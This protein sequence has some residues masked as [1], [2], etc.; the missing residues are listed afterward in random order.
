[1]NYENGAGNKMDHEIVRSEDLISVIIPVYNTKKYLD[2][3]LKSVFDQR[4][5]KLEIIIID[6]GSTDGTGELCDY[7]LDIDK[8]V[9]VFHKPN[10]GL[11]LTRNYGIKKSTGK[12]IC[13]LDSDDKILPD[14]IEDLYKGMMS[15]HVDI[16]KAGFTR[17]TESRELKK[18]QY[19][20]AV[21]KGE[22]VKTL[23]LPRLIGASPGQ[24]D[25]VEMA[26]CGVLYKANIIKD[27]NIIFPS[28]REFIS[29]DMIFNIH[30]FQYAAG[31]CLISSTGYYYRINNKSLTRSYR[32]DR[33]EAYKKF[34]RYVESQL[35]GYGYKENVIYRLDRYFF[36]CIRKCLQQEASNPN[37]NR[38]STCIKKICNDG[39]VSKV[40]NE[41]PCEKLEYKQRVFLRLI[42]SKNIIILKFLINA[43]LL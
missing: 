13:F 25:S 40:I 42:R 6:D 12:Y 32:A 20:D 10:D 29:E 22:N 15:N 19:V 38:V 8:R 27:H 30:Y 7:Y 31:G 28:E 23:F 1:M 39:L 34:Y 21:Y 3:C 9:K 16:C 4:Y 24:H 11:G 5:T 2:E 26:V 17:F 37:R 33:F 43:N 41:Y 36:I 14:F 18:I 35:N